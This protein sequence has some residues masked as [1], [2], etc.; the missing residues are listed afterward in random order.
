MGNEIAADFRRIEVE[1]VVAIGEKLNW[2]IKQ[3]ENDPIFF[4][5][6]YVGDDI[7]LKDGKP[8]SFMAFAT[9]KTGNQLVEQVQ[10]SS[11][12][13][14]CQLAAGNFDKDEIF[15]MK[16]FAQK[17]IELDQALRKELPFHGRAVELGN[18]CIL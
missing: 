14:G 8:R 7:P 3:R 9:K 10:L 17:I 11:V 15:I 5:F 6:Y 2:E 18:L 1:E 12:M 16:K 4:D 13:Y